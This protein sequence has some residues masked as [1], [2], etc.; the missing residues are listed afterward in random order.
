MKEFF[1]KNREK[2]A[3]YLKEKE[4][5]VLFSGIAPRHSNDHYYKFLCDKSY[6]YLTGLNRENFA[7][8]LRKKED[9]TLEETLFIEK[10]NPDVEK[11]T[12]RKLRIEESKEISGIEEVKFIEDFDSWFNSLFSE[13]KLKRLFLD[14]NRVNSKEAPTLS[15]RIAK[16]LKEKYI[17]LDISSATPILNELRFKKTEFEVEKIKKAIEITD[18]SF[19]ETLKELKPGVRE[20]EVCAKFAYS[21]AMLGSERLSFDSIVASGG[22]ACILHYE[23]G[24][25]T[26]KDGDLVLFDIGAQ[27]EQYASDISRTV[28][29]NG[30]FTERQKQIYEIVLRANEHTIKQVKPGMSSLELNNFTKKYLADELIKIGLIESEDELGKYYYHGVSHS[31]G[32]NTHDSLNRNSIIDVGMVITIEPGLYISEENIGIRI[33]DDVLVTEDGCINL[34]KDIIKSVEDIEAFMA[35]N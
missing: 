22:N 10:P 18:A 28:P 17:F 3:Q 8:A 6:Y 33:E 14:L 1:A 23:N 31:M 29:V 15:D 25:D 35:K 26:L 2:F 19:K 30:K 34:S 20:N 32:L 24:V 5:L 4:M 7:V 12:G 16:D 27:F 21:V 11:W 13:D 9:G